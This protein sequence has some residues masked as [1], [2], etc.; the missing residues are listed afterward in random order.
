MC[1]SRRASLLNNETKLRGVI[2]QLFHDKICIVN[3]FFIIRTFQCLT[4]SK[5]LTTAYS[6]ILLSLVR[7]AHFKNGWMQSSRYNDFALWI[8]IGVVWGFPWLGATDQRF[9]HKTQRGPAK[10]VYRAGFLNN[11]WG[12]DTEYEQGFRTGPPGYIGWRNS[13]LGIDSWVP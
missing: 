10:C 13:F 9:C 3:S 6:T 11:L 2:W 5:L 7:E 8:T 4:F 12:L 1:G